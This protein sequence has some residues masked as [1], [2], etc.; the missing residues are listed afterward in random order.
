[1]YQHIY[2]SCTLA[3]RKHSPDP[4]C[5]QRRLQAAPAGAAGSAMFRRGLVPETPL[6]GFLG[7]LDTPAPGNPCTDPTRPWCLNSQATP[8]GDLPWRCTSS[9]P[10]CLM[11]DL[12]QCE[13]LPLG[14]LVASRTRC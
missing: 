1:M 6:N 2:R 7:H 13:V 10:L 4:L 12:L 14:T 9:A 5:R 11:P 8:A 3:R